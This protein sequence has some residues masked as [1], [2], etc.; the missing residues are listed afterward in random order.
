MSRYT[1]F[2]A[3]V[4]I[5][6]VEAFSLGSGQTD[7]GPDMPTSIVARDSGVYV[8]GWSRRSATG[9]DFLTVKYDTS[10]AIKWSRSVSEN[11]L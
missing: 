9:M 6:L 4:A 11:S 7:G 1:G 3:A 8:A 5:V 10:G 2:A